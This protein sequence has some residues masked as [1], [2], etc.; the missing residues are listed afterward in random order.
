MVL[1]Q[2]IRKY[3]PT[4]SKYQILAD[5]RSY[6]QAVMTH[7]HASQDTCPILSTLP[8][9]SL[10]TLCSYRYKLSQLPSTCI[11]LT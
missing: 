6:N 11:T 10:D 8:H 3:V 9:N 2:F 1:F 4:L 7:P 5:H